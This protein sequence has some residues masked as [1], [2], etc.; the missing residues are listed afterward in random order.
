VP[1][2]S[3]SECRSGH[4]PNRLSAMLAAARSNPWIPTFALVSAV[5][6]SM[7]FGTLHALQGADSIV[8][9]LVSLQRWTPF[10][11]QQDRF[12]MLV[13]LLVMPVRDPLANLVVQG[14]LMSTAALLAPFLVAR[15]LV[16]DPCEWFVAGALTNIL[17]L[18]LPRPDVQFDWL[19]VQ[20]Y[21][22]STALGTAGLILS[23]KSGR[24]ALVATVLMVLAHWVNLSVVVLVAPLALLRRR[25]VMRSITITMTITGVG[26]GVGAALTR[27]SPY[28]TTTAVLPAADWPHG[29]YDLLA[30]ATQ[31][32]PHRAA[33]V[34]VAMLGVMATVVVWRR[35]R[36]DV[37]DSIGRQ[38]LAAAGTAL[39]VGAT[40]WLVA[41]VSRWVQLNIYLPRYIY[42]SVL[43]C[44]VAFG[45]VVAALVRNLSRSMT[46]GTALSLCV[47][48]L[49]NYGVPSRA[50]L[51]ATLD[52]RLG[53]LTPDV[54]ASGATVIG[55]NYWV[56][57]P[58]V[59]HANLM[60]HRQKGR[61][62]YGLTYR[63]A[64][65]DDLWHN[66]PADIVIAAPAGDRTI[67][68]WARKA[69]LRITRL[70]RRGAI[71]VFV[72][73]RTPG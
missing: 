18:L 44:G 2:H 31:S 8:P 5:A 65:T 24:T 54:I 25:S 50:R 33:L 40:Y 61:A 53:A 6:T 67:D 72:G 58:A 39:F 38:R 16:D 10:F 12:G 15:L 49:F 23:E 1:D 68:A 71:D 3:K 47:L 48:T 41:G 46:L 17:L 36:R 60:T 37:R 19:V 9:I 42:P 55:G 52:S 43:M 63:S 45:I 28:H 7:S 64:P 57:W 13:P 73:R 27:L 70:E 56:I 21:A 29:W 20:P 62:V 69:G 22:L 35:C 32:F 11:W 4:W 14:W 66:S 30:N 51:R 34:V 59:F 26:V